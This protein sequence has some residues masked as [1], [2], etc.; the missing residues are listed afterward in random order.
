MHVNS[1]GSTDCLWRFQWDVRTDPYS[2]PVPHYQLG[3]LV[4]LASFTISLWGNVGRLNSISGACQHRLGFGGLKSNDHLCSTYSYPVSPPLPQTL[5]SC[6]KNK[7]RPT[8]KLACDYADLSLTFSTSI[9][10]RKSGTNTGFDLANVTDWH[11][12]LQVVLW[13]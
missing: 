10:D 1:T 8:S 5:Q 4:S 7:Q 9:P 12:L 13:K 3:C 2:L 11:H 6:T